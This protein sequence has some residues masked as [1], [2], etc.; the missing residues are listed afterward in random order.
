MGAPPAFV[1]VAVW[2]EGA[3]LIAVGVTIG[4][5]L[6]LPLLGVVSAYASQ[7]TGLA[8]AATLGGPELWL[9]GS[10]LAGASVAAALPSLSLLWRPV[11]GLLR[12]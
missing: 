7:R 11:A 6:C 8:V 9:L 5:L 10:T 1:L 12:S 2:L 4:A 3:M